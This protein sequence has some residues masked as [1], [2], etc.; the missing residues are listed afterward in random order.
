MCGTTQYYSYMWA[1]C[2]SSDCFAAFEE[3][4]LDDANAVAAVGKRYRETILALGGSKPAMDVF[5]EFRG[6]K[7]NTAALLRHSGLGV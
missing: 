6:R 4:D 5:V 2:M 1:N 3:A 7:P